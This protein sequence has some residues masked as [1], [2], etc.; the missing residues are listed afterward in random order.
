MFKNTFTSINIPHLPYLAIGGKNWSYY[1]LYTCM[2]HTPLAKA[3][4][5]SPLSMAYTWYLLLVSSAHEFCKQFGPRSGPTERQHGHDPN[6]L[7][8]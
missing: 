5:F 3:C 7:T 1:N 6:C 2:V 8:L 4:R